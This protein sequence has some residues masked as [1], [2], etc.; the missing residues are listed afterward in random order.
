MFY[1]HST[2]DKTKGNWQSLNNH[3]TDVGRLAANFAEGF[4]GE[5]AA[6][7]AGLLHDLGKYNPLIQAYYEG[8]GSSVD[9][10]TAGAAVL[11]QQAVSLPKE[12]L[13]DKITLEL[14]AH[15]IAGHHA[16]LPNRLDNE[17]AGASLK[18]RFEAW[19]VASL[20]ASWQEEITF[21][22]SEL[23]PKGFSSIAGSKEGIAFQIAFLGRMIFS[24]L[25]DA[26]FKDTEAFYAAVKQ[27]EIDRRWSPLS[28][29]ID[30][31]IVSFDAHMIRLEKQAAQGGAT[32]LNTLRNT[33]LNTV[34]VKATQA[35]G[36]FTL[37]VPT[38]GGKTLASLGFA[39][40]HARQH[41]KQRIIYAIPFT[42]I[43]DQT[44][45]IFKDVLGDNVILEH[46]SAIDEESVKAR[47]QADKLKLAME[48]WAAPVIVTT[49]VQLFESLFAS[50][51][52][53]CRKLHNIANSIIILDEAQTLP[54]GLLKPCVVALGELARNYGCTI[55]LCTATQP[56]LNKQH[57]DPASLMGLEILGRELAPDP[58]S[59]AR[60]LKRVNIVQRGEMTDDTL[61]SEL[62]EQAQGLVIV[63][64]R[65]HA[66]QLFHLCQERGL[67]GLVHLTTRQCAAHRAQVL[68]EVRET[69]RQDRDCK[70]IATSL[71]EAGVDIDFPKLWRAEAGLEQVLQ[72]AGRCNR[73]GRRIL[74]QSYVNVFKPSEHKPP[75]EIE[76]LVY[77]YQKIASRFADL[78]QP[79]AI[80]A[81]FKEVYWQRGEGLDEG[82]ILSLAQ[83][84][85]SGTNIAY[86]TIAENF[87]MIKSP[88]LP[89]IVAYD[90]HG[91]NWINKLEEEKVPSGLIA[92]KLQR[93]VVLVPKDKRIELINAGQVAFKAPELRGDQFAVLADKALYNSDYGLDWDAAGILIDGIV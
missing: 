24:C 64:T 69:L 14:I 4:G 72:A 3:L 15:A 84:D 80:E 35:P 23:W 38:G 31:L 16:G 70:V 30:G 41:N 90:S 5:R 77:A 76:L 12:L 40:D 85:H 59:L 13:G 50:R 27:N 68:Q 6:R 86:R 45:S 56:A 88:Q 63:N 43:I 75:K 11:L 78:F 21:E 34:R 44:A 52:S 36:V 55:V 10:S 53:R 48:D 62:S 65:K 81:Y 51:P 9:H 49:N 57:Y 79:E 22:S 89:V 29:I 58:A 19:R 83:L 87:N 8:K 17:G 32:E 33:I 47:Q 71:I 74:E 66:L 54:L 46:H 25:V 93:H 42:S 73:E 61:V 7:L 37:N 82:K 2:D 39:L 92:R 1:A 28:D 18:K 60:K 20:D 26:D 67:E 91:D